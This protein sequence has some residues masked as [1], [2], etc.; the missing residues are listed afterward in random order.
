[1][2]E[3]TN[4]EILHGAGNPSD[5]VVAC[6]DCHYIINPDGTTKPFK[7]LPNGNIQVV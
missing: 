7:V 6:F 3:H 2:C 1:M 4:T 5:I